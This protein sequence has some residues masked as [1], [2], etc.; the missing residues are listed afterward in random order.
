MPFPRLPIWRT[1]VALLTAVLVFSFAA[2]LSVRGPASSPLASPAG[3]WLLT[4]EQLIQVVESTSTDP[5]NVGRAIVADVQLV[6]GETDCAFPPCPPFYTLSGSSYTRVGPGPGVTVG[7]LPTGASC[8]SPAGDC[9]GGNP[10][11]GRMAVIVG[12]G[13]VTFLGWVRLGPAGGAWTPGSI[14]TLL[15]NP[16]SL[17]G[18]LVVVDG[19][20]TGYG[21]AINCPAVV[22]DGGSVP[23]VGSGG[24]WEESYGCGDAA[25]ITTQRYVSTTTSSNSVAVH[26]PA[27]GI[28]V[29]NGAYEAFGLPPSN[30]VEPRRGLYLIDPLGPV[31]NCFDCTS[32]GGV[33]RVVAR[34]DPIQLRTTTDAP[35]RSDATNPPTASANPATSE[36]DWLLDQAGLVAA[37]RAAQATGQGSGQAVVA[38][39][40]FGLGGDCR[41]TPDP[42]TC[43]PIVSG[44]DP[45]IRLVDP[46]S[47]FC[48]STWRCAFKQQPYVPSGGPV[49]LRLRDD[50]SVQWLDWVYTQNDGTL[51]WSFDQFRERLGRL[52][53]TERDAY[54]LYVVSGWI[55]GT[56]AMIDCAPL[57][58]LTDSRFFCSDH[59]TWFVGSAPASPLFQGPSGNFRL[60]PPGSIQLQNGAFELISP[61]DGSL[62]VQGTLLVRPVVPPPD[63]CMCDSGLAAE[64]VGRLDQP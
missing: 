9:A 58:P 52:Q 13:S 27:D 60:V 18:R 14:S 40:M 16:T 56:E 3:T 26:P 54:E 59:P 63:S 22:P 62:V 30:L 46:P 21:G 1:G 15:A 32:T 42:A 49:A 12:R 17:Q 44:S 39:A 38:N 53:F 34:I 41:G 8:P 61:A 55:T 28:R 64:V 51:E 48:P 24:H 57:P 29:Q 37:V 4:N 2:S 6:R 25:W 47:T 45:P 19:W 5:T 33:G 7:G 11:A 35:A 31:E 10:S 43:Y 20:L 23:R 50:G 36:A